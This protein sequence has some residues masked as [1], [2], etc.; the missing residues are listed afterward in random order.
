MPFVTSAHLKLPDAV[1]DSGLLVGWS[2]EAL[3]QRQPFGFTFGHSLKTVAT[4]YLDP[5]VLSG[6]GHLMTIAP[7]G[8]GKGTGCVIP[9]L[10]R[11]EG[12][13]IVI[14]PKGENAAVTARRRRE[15]GHRIVVIDPMGVTDLPS[16]TLN[17][18]DLID[19]RDA[20]AV[21]EAAVIA[22][23]LCQ[24][25]RDPRDTFW[26]SRA[27]HLV[28]GAIL[29]AL[30]EDPHGSAS[31]LDAGDLV[32]RAAANPADAASEFLQSNHPEVRRIARTLEIGASETIG[33]IVS[34]AQEM[35]SFLRGDRVQASIAR[36]SFDL[37]DITTGAPLSIYLVLPPHM[38]ESHGRLLRLWIGT[39]MSCITRRRGR[40]KQPTLLILD[41]AAQLGELP[42][43]RQAITLLRGYGVQTWSF[44]QDV[45]Q[46]QLL[47]PR[48]WQTMVNNCSVLQCFGALNQIAASGMS[49]LTGF[50]DGLGV[51]DLQRDE[52]VLQIAGD[53]AVVARVPSYLADP[54]FAG[55][56][57][58]NPLHD[59][60]RPLL[61]ERTVPQRLY[62]RPQAPSITTAIW[63]VAEDDPLLSELAA[64]STEPRN[65]TGE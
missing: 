51:L 43:L 16:D 56:F 4:G 50:A 35:L 37:D 15:M 13:V 62:A 55:Q 2:L 27:T 32:N 25:A 24:V 41:E 53:Q 3:R 36:T 38:L 49:A 52:M 61:P 42:Q 39:L 19:I 12:P 59:S 21:D 33:G 30:S 23:T 44:W 45:S 10:L 5:I 9:A 58:P 63:A 26:I 22:G 65:L 31:L 18:L 46:L 29:H 14:D 6:E 17:P 7:T 57:D 11:H 48:D 47:Y 1:S 8:A 20:S 64:G 40:P 34:F 60:S 54:S 28:V